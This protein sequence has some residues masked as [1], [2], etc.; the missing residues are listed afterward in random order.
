M[1]TL[2]DLLA[3]KKA[4]KAINREFYTY[5]KHRFDIVKNWNHLP[6]FWE[7]R[8]GKTILTIRWAKHH[9]CKKVLI[10][11]PL[12]VR[13]TWEKEL[14]LEKEHPFVITKKT[15]ALV[16]IMGDGFYVTNY[17]AIWSLDL[18]KDNQIQWDCVILDESTKVRKETSK[19]SKICCEMFQS[20]PHKAIL[21]G[22]PAPETLADYFQQYKFLFGEFMG[23][24]E[25]HNWLYRYSSGFERGK[26]Q[27][28]GN[29][30]EIQEYIKENSSSLKRY[31]VKIGSKK[32]YNVRETQFSPRARTLYDKFERS[33]FYSNQNAR[34]GDGYFTE[35][36]IVAQKMLH[37]MTG[38]I[39]KHEDID[40]HSDH[41][42]DDLDDL[43]KEEL[44]NEQVVIWSAYRAEIEMIRERLN[45]KVIH[46]GVS[47]DERN[48]LLE[49]FHGQK[50]PY[51]CC[52]L[53]TAG[54]GLDMSCADTAIYYSNSWEV[55]HRYQS[56][57]RIIHPKKKVP[58]LYIDLVTEDTIDDDIRVALDEKPKKTGLYQEKIYEAFVKR[59]ERMIFGKDK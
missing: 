7:M 22:F 8:L 29:A 44:P 41:K 24:T 49:G 13:R 2:E 10:V 30:R 55:E 56:E 37:Q 45:C 1:P 19:I 42:L 46:G 25:F 32:L 36:S 33:W 23:Y 31:E 20:V 48:R 59:V 53:K 34:N 39:V 27:F 5:Q 47:N 58:I 12:T 38:G 18:F 26:P 15:Q 51:L 14:V 6:L 17:E 43:L 9:K 35:W 16:P 11:C 57:D 54:M 40:F 3:K 21:S 28:A 4:E 50:F 52:Q